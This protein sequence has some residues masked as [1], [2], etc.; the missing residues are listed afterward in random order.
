VARTNVGQVTWR[1]P[2]R[3]K[4]D[5]SGRPVRTISVEPDLEVLIHV[6]VHQGRLACIGADLRSFVGQST[7]RVTEYQYLLGHDEYSSIGSQIWRS[8]PIG[9]LVEEAIAKARKTHLAMGSGAWD[10]IPGW[11]TA[12]NADHRAVAEIEGPVETRGRKAIFTDKVLTEVVRPAYLTGGRKPVQAV[13]LALQRAGLP[14]SGPD[15]QV[16]LDQARKAVAKARKAGI[17]PP[18]QKRGKA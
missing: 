17:I 18:A 13:K 11:D 14:S 12:W 4:I 9:E 16:T 7:L 15:G 10:Q 6:G 2:F 1:E 3:F 8:I 5:G